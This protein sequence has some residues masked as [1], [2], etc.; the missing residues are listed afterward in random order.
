MMASFILLRPESFSLFLSY[1]NLG[2]P[3]RFTKQKA[4]FAEISRLFTFY[5]ARK[6]SALTNRE[7]NAPNF[8]ANPVPF[9][10]NKRSKADFTVGNEKKR[11]IHSR[12]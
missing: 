2:I 6:T 7:A 4:L 9:L 1:L 11:N 8:R 10:H 3:A 12:L 5:D